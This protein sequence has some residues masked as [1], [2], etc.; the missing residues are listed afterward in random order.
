[1]TARQGRQRRTVQRVAGGLTPA[2]NASGGGSQRA[3]PG[4]VS[5]PRLADKQWQAQVLALARLYGYR[6]YHVYDARRSAPGFTDLVLVR[7]PRVIFV[8]LK[9]DHGR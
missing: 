4:G 6:A 5:V 7:R 3:A 8:E 9:T 1:M 2:R